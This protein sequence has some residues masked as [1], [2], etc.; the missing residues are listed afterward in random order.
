MTIVKMGWHTGEFLPEDPTSLDPRFEQDYDLH[1]LRGT[2]SMDL[3]SRLMLGDD[4]G[5]FTRAD[6]AQLPPDVRGVAFFGLIDAASAGGFQSIGGVRV[7]NRTGEVEATASLPSPRLRSFLIEP[8]VLTTAGA[9][10]LGPPFRVLIHESVTEIWLTPSTL[11]LPADTEKQRFTVLARFDDDT[12]GDITRLAASS[13][14]AGA[15]PP[16]G[17]TWSSSDNTCARVDA[18]GYLS[19]VFGLFSCSST[20]TATLRQPGWPNL[21]ATATVTVVEPWGDPPPNRR[22][23]HLVSGPGIT[24][25]DDVPNILFLPDGFTDT[26]GDRDDFDKLV[27][28]LVHRITHSASTEP[29][30]ALSGSMNYWSV[31]VPS[32]ENG[33]STLDDLVE[34][35]FLYEGVEIFGT[36]V[37]DVTVDGPRQAG[38][39]VIDFVR[40]RPFVGHLPPNVRFTIAGDPTL[41]ATTNDVKVVANALRQVRFTPGLARDVAANTAVTI[42]TARF[43]PNKVVNELQVAALTN[44][45]HFVGLPVPAERLAQRSNAADLQAKVADW[46]T[47]YGAQRIQ[48]ANI[49]N[50]IYDL[51]AMRFPDHRLA[52]EK[53]TAFGLANVDRPRSV[54]K[55][56]DVS[57]DWHPF[58]TSRRDLDKYLNKLQ[59]QGATIGQTWTAQGGRDRELV[60]ILANGVRYSGSNTGGPQ[61]IVAFGLVHDPGV[62]VRYGPGRSMQLVSY[63]IP[64]DRANDPVVSNELHAR[65][66]HEIAHSFGV[67]DEYGR[68][69]DGS[70]GA[71]P[72]G[73]PEEQRTFTSGNVTPLHEVAAGTGITGD[74]LRWRWPRIRSAGV[75]AGPPVPD[76]T[77]AN[78]FTI[79]LIPGRPTNIPGD[80]F[81]VGDTVFLR[82]RPLYKPSQA[83]PPTLTPALQSP[84]LAVISVADHQVQVR[85]Q[86]GSLTPADFSATGFDAPILF[87]PVPAA[88]SAAAAHD[89]YAEI[90]SQFIR[91]HITSSGRPLNA[92]P[93]PNPAQPWVCTPPGGDGFIEAQQARNLPPAARFPGGRIPAIQSRI[94]GAYEGGATFSCGIYHPAGACIMRAPLAT[95][96]ERGITS[97]D[98]G[99]V[100]GF[101]AVCR[102]LIVDRV[103]PRL[104]W[105]IDAFYHDYPQP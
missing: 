92:L 72:V 49:T 34:F 66:V 46:T 15:A 56:E 64:R 79:R 70:P 37:T 25:N 69:A 8:R 104:H 90:M 103:D 29:F 58:R 18:F 89:Q 81:N 73:G 1:V 14:S 94:I 33:T 63:P 87:S 99:D 40:A 78:F 48:A 45:V 83:N 91:A 35:P 74:K 42:I 32:R 77:V 95:G 65:S 23:L 19:G 39:A 16:S 53:D 102:Y 55:H 30:N 27:A 11:T 100:H 96:N 22:E 26:P 97:F 41:Y 84:P 3:H 57:L 59:F 9:T 24:P 71:M 82:Q 36:P 5:K 80:T 98:K 13:P 86:S 52:D 51:W 38:A 60:F 61:P 50:P 54:N 17:F 68:I 76:P 85:L 67:N 43:P 7:N 62:M 31:F 2:T 101:C 10:L 75:L 12:V 4:A 28:F 6:A 105:L 20:I 88:A 21:S 47:L 44:L 93:L